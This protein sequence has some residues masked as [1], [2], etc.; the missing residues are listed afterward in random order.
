[1]HDDN[2]N[3]SIRKVLILKLS[4]EMKES[5]NKEGNLPSSFPFQN[6]CYRIEKACIITNP[7]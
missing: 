2:E 4:I 7:A 5:S 3:R 6:D 1:M